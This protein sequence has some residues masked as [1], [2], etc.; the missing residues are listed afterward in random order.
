MVCVK[1]PNSGRCQ[2]R[3]IWHQPPNRDLAEADRWFPIAGQLAPQDFLLLVVEENGV[4]RQV[5]TVCVFKEQRSSLRCQ[6]VSGDKRPVR[7]VNESAGDLIG[8]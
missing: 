3:D 8:Y 4:E 7:I 1:F 5:V 2:D 6:M